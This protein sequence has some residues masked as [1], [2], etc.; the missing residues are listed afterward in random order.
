MGTVFS[1]AVSTAPRWRRPSCPP[2]PRNRT[3]GP[4]ND[5]PGTVHWPGTTY[6]QAMRLADTPAPPRA[7]GQ[8][9]G[10]AVPAVPAGHNRTAAAGRADSAAAR[11][12][13]V[14]DPVFDAPW[15]R[16]WQ[17]A[18]RSPR[19]G[20]TSS[21]GLAGPQAPRAARGR[22]GRHRLPRRR[23]GGEGK[24]MLLYDPAGKAAGPGPSAAWCGARGRGRGDGG[25]PAASA[26]L[27]GA[28]LADALDLHAPGYARPSGT[29]TRVITEGYGAKSDDAPSTGFELRASWCPADGGT[30]R[31]RRAA[32]EIRSAVAA[33]CELLASAAGLPAAGTAA[34]G[35]RARTRR[36]RGPGAAR[37]GFGRGAAA[38]MT[39]RRARNERAKTP[40]PAA[41]TAAAG[42]PGGGGGDHGWADEKR[43][44]RRRDENRSGRSPTCSNRARAC[45]R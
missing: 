21:R 30:R 34:I 45:R 27:A 6:A 31:R 13:G 2:V 23:G 35:G 16:S 14:G 29:L 8:A 3:S 20:T 37:P 10:T 44:T 43:S 11:G 38:P 18:T 12:P 17:A 41:S 40:D 28:R 25:R 1:G 15:P 36:R 19:P 9:H 24:F 32:A 4:L 7:G 42:G 33:W 26:R 22:A 5:H 39:G